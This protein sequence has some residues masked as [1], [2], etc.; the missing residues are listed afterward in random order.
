VSELQTTDGIQALYLFSERS[1]RYVHNS[2][3]PAL[4]LQIPP[5]FVLLHEPFLIPFWREFEFNWGYAQDLLINII[6]FV[7][8]GVVF[9]LYWISARPI[10]HPVA[11]TVLLGFAASLTIEVLQSYLPTR[12]SGTTDLFTN[13]LGTSVG[14]ALCRVPAVQRLA[15]RIL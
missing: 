8:L 6:G 4:D 10:Q 15:A 7:P 14:I 1:G 3:N 9:Y 13:T 11:A 2:V 5:R 12:N